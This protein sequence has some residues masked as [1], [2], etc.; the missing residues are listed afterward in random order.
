MI[1]FI[2]TLTTVILSVVYLIFVGVDCDI[3]VLQNFTAAVHV[4]KNSFRLQQ[5]I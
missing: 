4:W 5:L 2:S 1:C 3:F